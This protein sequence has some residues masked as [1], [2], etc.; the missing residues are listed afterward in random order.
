MIRVVIA[1]DSNSTAIILQK[2]MESD[3]FIRVIGRAKDGHEAIQLVKKLKPDIVTMDMY[4]PKV[5]GY[6]ATKEIMLTTPLPILIV[7]TDS[8]KDEMSL[9]F[10]AME[11]GALDIIQK[12]SGDHNRGY[13]ELGHEINRKI[14]ILSKIKPFDRHVIRLSQKTEPRKSVS[15]LNTEKIR[16]IVIGASTGGPLALKV[17]FQEL[18]ANFPIPF[19]V[20]Q[21]ITDGFL[22][23][24]VEWLNKEIPLLTKV[25]C[26]G[27]KILSGKVYF[28]PTD[29]HLGVDSFGIIRLSKDL[30]IEG[31]RPSVNYLL[32]S[33]AAAFP[34][35]CL[36]IVLTGMGGDGAQGLKRL[37][38]T[39][40][41]TM[42]Q[43]EKSCTVFGMPKEALR[44]GGAELICPLDKI[45]DTIKNLI[46]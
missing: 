32:T 44:L 41:R 35:K 1:E 23:G 29:F 5:D 12:P 15:Y 8:N 7:S 43:D 24:L 39:G 34:K 27:E 46:A 3:P 6:A 21:H 14:R 42:V 2:I 20:V 38:E 18:P 33:A 9:S 40:S 45:A 19:L 36:G 13:K 4:M 22:D 28:A 37:K 10:K 31:Y 16:L 30:P 17:I 11:A 26:H 25:A